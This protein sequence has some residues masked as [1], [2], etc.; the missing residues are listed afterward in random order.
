ME[1][2][3]NTL[4]FDFVMAYNGGITKQTNK[5]AV[6]MELLKK[7][8][9]PGD[10]K[11]SEIIDLLLKEE[12]GYL[13]SAPV[14]V[15]AETEINDGSFCAG[16]ASL[17]KLKLVCEGEFGEFSFPVY[18]SC[19]FSEGE[20]LPCF[21]HINFRDN[22][23]DKYQPTEE[24]IDSGYAVMSFCY[25]DVT[26]DNADFTDGLA[27]VIYPE[28]RKSIYD[29]GKIGLWAWA[30]MRVMDYAVTLP[31][32][33]SSKISVAGH[34]RLGKTALL[35]GALDERFY[36]AFSNDSGNSGAALAR[37]N[38]GETIKDI[39]DRFPFWFCE[40]YAQYSDNETSLPFDQHYL[41][42]ANVP[43][44]VYVASADKDQ[45]ACPDNEYMS[46]IAADDYYKKYGPGGFCHPDRKAVVGDF[47]FEGAIGYHKRAGKHYMSRED[48]NYYIK[49]LEYHKNK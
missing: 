14:K 6:I 21:I 25:E 16:K 39:Y 27:G 1:N 13:P 30:A 29:C 2:K 43:H 38:T 15:Y 11:K 31:E 9:M 34:S 5:G 40:N 46:C 47:F 8:P 23:P 26:K 45:W 22:V 49:Y 10:M 19:P 36:C 24:I 41:I 33:D 35:A 32:L 7:I 18:Y 17:K 48:W 37:E 42:A 28:G 4:D 44:L 12:Y 3:K 20:K